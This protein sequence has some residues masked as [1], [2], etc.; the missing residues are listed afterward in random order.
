MQFQS[1]VNAIRHSMMSNIS[2]QRVTEIATLYILLMS[3]KS[4]RCFVRKK[5]LQLKSTS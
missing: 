1:H 3:H 4:L 5:K 2:K